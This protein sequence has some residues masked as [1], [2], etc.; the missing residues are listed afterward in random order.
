MCSTAAPTPVYT[1]TVFLLLFLRNLSL[2]ISDGRAGASGKAAKDM[3]LPV[4][5]HP[6]L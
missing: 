1:G 3:A 6:E 5:E 4:S 2:K